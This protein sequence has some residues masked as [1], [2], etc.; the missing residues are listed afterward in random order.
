[1]KR[2]LKQNPAIPFGV[3]GFLLSA[4]RVVGRYIPHQPTRLPVR[5][6]LVGVVHHARAVRIA[7][8]DLVHHVQ[9]QAVL[10]HADRGDEVL[11]ELLR[12]VD[13]LEVQIHHIVVLIGAHRLAVRVE[14]Q[15]RL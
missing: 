11:R 12:V 9:E 4:R 6:S 5:I 3:A 7:D 14:T 13:A 8:D 1:M 10:D 15:H 2:P